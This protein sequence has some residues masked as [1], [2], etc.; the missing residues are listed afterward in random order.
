MRIVN[1]YWLAAGL[2][3]IAAN[4]SAHIVNIQIGAAART[5]GPNLSGFDV[6]SSTGSNLPLEPVRGVIRSVPVLD[7]N[8]TPSCDDPVCNGTS[9]GGLNFGFVSARGL[10]IPCSGSGQDIQPLQ[11]KITGGR[12]TEF[13]HVLRLSSGGGEVI[14]LS[15]LIRLRI[16]VP[17]QT[18]SAF[19]NGDL[20][21][22]DSMSASFML[23]TTAGPVPGSTGLILLLGASLTLLGLNRL[24]PSGLSRR[25]QTKGNAMKDIRQV[26]EISIWRGGIRLPLAAIAIALTALS[27]NGQSLPNLFLFPNDSG[28]LATYNTANQPIDLTGP[29][30]RSLGSN[31]RRCSSCHV[32]AQGWSVSAA[33]VKARFEITQGLD[34]IFRTND[35]SNCDHGIDTSTVGG[36]RR[37]YSL[38]TDRGLMRIAIQVPDNAEFN[39]ISVVNP[40]GCGDTA[41]LS[42]YRRPLPAANLRFLSAVMWDGRESSTQ[43]GTQSITF[44]TNP[45]DL[46]AD[47]AHQAV[48]ATMG[49]AQGTTP[50]MPKEQQAIVDFEMSLTTAQAFDYRAGALN[51]DGAAGGPSAIGTRT[52]PAFFVGINDPL[53]GN[54]HGTP[55]SPIVFKLFDAWMPTTNRD[56]G[57]DDDKQNR[58][59]SIARGQALFNSKPIQIVGVGGL[60]DDL[61][62]EIGRASCR[63]RV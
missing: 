63:E 2:L 60:N 38:L 35:G 27:A 48:D 33:G 34:P 30:F 55:F 19:R 11:E 52:S 56:D 40:Y 18:F 8:F 54:P 12:V 16:T 26:T 42:L 41:I 4:A 10:N 43:T 23:T 39:V 61:N 9:T 49:H 28:W 21:Q 62:L 57:G 50:L 14:D 13:S 31:G 53:G 51:V 44:A 24:R 32:P 46:L 20:A 15:N 58:R 5:I 3:T 7:L 17:A 36:R 45:G 37:A 22:T 29:F 25:S 1:L 47:L 6:V 59:A